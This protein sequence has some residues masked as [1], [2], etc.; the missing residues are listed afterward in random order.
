MYYS[1]RLSCQITKYNNRIKYI[2]I[3]SEYIFL[4]K[5]DIIPRDYQ[6]DAYN[7]LKDSKISVLDM[8]CGMGKTIISYLLS[9]DYNNIIILTPKIS[10]CEQIAFHYK[11]YYGN[12]V[13]IIQINCQNERNPNIKLKEK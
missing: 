5:I 12:A 2:N 7:K 11:N 6:I 8:P 1:G 13:N 3:P 10:T 9:L 4:N